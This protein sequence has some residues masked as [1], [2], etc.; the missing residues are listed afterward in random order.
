VTC[1]VEPTFRLLDAR[2]GWDAASATGLVGLQRVSGITLRALHPGEVS[3]ADA[4]KYFL[5]RRLAEGPERCQWLLAPKRGTRLLRL[6]ACVATD[7][8][9]ADRGCF[10]PW[11]PALLR[12]NAV[13]AACG[14]IAI[15]DAGG[16]EVVVVNGAA[17]PHARFA[18]DRPRAVA[19]TPWRELWVADAH[20]DLRRFGLDGTPQAPAAHGLGRPVALR[21][22]NS[23]MWLLHARGSRLT[24]ACFDRRGARRPDGLSRLRRELAPGA[25]GAWGREG[26]CWAEQPGPVADCIDWNGCPA[27][28]PVRP[29]GRRALAPQGQL[30]IVPLDSENPR[31]TWHRV[32]ADAD[33]PPGTSLSFDYATV[34]AVGDVP[35]WRRPEGN[36]TDFLV[37]APPGQLLALRMTLIGDGFQTPRVR[38]VRVDFP[39]A[40]SA[41]FLPAVYREEARAADFTER[42]VALFDAEIECLDDVI[43]TFPRWLHAG[44]APDGALAWLGGLIGLSFDSNMTPAQRRQLID[45]APQLFAARGTPYGLLRVL[46]IVTGQTIA[47]VE[48]RNPFGAVASGG[49][50]CAPA[51]SDFPGARLNETRLFGTAARRARVGRSLLGRARVRSL[52]NPDMDPFSDAAFRIDV[53][54]PPG[55]ATSDK[56]RARLARMVEALKPAHVLARVRFGG[57]GGGFVVGTHAVVGVD[58][59]LTPAPPPVLGVRAR[60]SRHTVLWPSARARGRGLRLEFPILG[61]TPL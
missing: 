10:A 28:R 53:H 49:A 23:R 48:Q 27:D 38:R 4:A 51:D 54:F 18:V 45:E 15:A 36:P 9:P 42:F 22:S 33:V 30:V 39:R 58:T 32:R 37:L 52:G 2:V 61:A 59:A 46:E 3:A 40:T 8:C 25:V 17:E 14:L 55:A 20:G 60:L 5:P 43:A 13:A 16:G 6:S 56:A 50:A 29:F 34:D 31:T 24:L 41:D 47:L 1:V 7:A 35:E 12:P 19:I 11:G 26:F 21:A 44:S 57:A